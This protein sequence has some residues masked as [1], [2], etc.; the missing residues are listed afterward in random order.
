[1]DD[2]LGLVLQRVEVLSG[3][4]TAVV[5]EISLGDHAGGLQ[6]LCVLV[7]PGTGTGPQ[8]HSRTEVT[9]VLDVLRVLGVTEAYSALE[10]RVNLA[11]VIVDPELPDPWQSQH[12][13]LVENVPVRGSY[14]TRSCPLL[15]ARTDVGPA[16]YDAI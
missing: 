1:M 16:E 6:F 12:S 13:V 3:P 4:T 10:I 8:P 14:R 9:S 5:T 15:P 2:H 11:G 7:H